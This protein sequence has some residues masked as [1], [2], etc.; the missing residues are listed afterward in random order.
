MSSG[1]VRTLRLMNEY[2][3]DWPLWDADGPMGPDDV[4][5][6]SRLRADLASW[7]RQF[8]EH[9]DPFSGWDDPRFREAHAGAAA[10]LLS[11]LVA[12]LGPGYSVELHL[13]EV[14]P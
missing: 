7:T 10:E 1:E 11:R 5:I 2:G 13:W 6:S 8:T 3:C 9:Y 12:E 4:E 14:A